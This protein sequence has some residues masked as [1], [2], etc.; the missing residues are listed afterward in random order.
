MILL[1]QRKP[2]LKNYPA[3]QKK[4]HISGIFAGAGIATLPR[5]RCIL[6]NFYRAVV[7]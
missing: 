7:I 4:H 6:V 1:K 5:N 3:G 2:R